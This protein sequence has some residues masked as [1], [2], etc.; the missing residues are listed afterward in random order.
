MIRIE[1]KIPKLK[2]Q[3]L[4]TRQLNELTLKNVLLSGVI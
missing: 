4:E 3:L 2:Q 1:K